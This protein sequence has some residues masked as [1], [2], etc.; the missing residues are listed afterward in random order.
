MKKFHIY[1]PLMALTVM[2]VLMAN[3][4]GSQGGFTGSPGDNGITCTNCHNGT[5]QT[6]T[7]WITTNVPVTGYVSGEEY[8]ITLTAEDAAAS[9]FGFEITSEDSEKSKIASFG[10]L[11]TTE[12]KF[13]NSNRAVTHTANG[14]TPAG[15]T[16]TWSFTWTAPEENKGDITFYASVNAAN[17]NGFSSGDII[18][19]TSKKIFSSANRI[20]DYSDALRLYPN[21]SEGL[22]NIEVSSLSTVRNLL[23]YNEKGQEVKRLS[24]SSGNQQID[25]SILPKGLYFLRLQEGESIRFQKLVLY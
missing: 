2:M 13:T 3:K 18:Y 15:N 9:K 11:N 25:L 1:L 16:K 19:K 23:I 22:V 8:E 5:P 20:S 12:T 7:G 21:P 24:L 10:L 6:V 4:S 14:I 17:G